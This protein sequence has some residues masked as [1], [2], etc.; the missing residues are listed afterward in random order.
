MLKEK[1]GDPSYD[2]MRTE[3][4]AAASKSALAAA[5][6]GKSLPSWETTWEFVR[7]LEVRVLGEDAED[8]RRRWQARWEECRALLDGDDRPPPG[9]DRPERAVAG[10]AERAE[11]PSTDLSTDGQARRHANGQTRGHMDRPVAM[12]QTEAE[13]G[14]RARARPPRRILF[15]GLAIALGYVLGLGSPAA[16]WLLRQMV[17]DA[18]GRPIPGDAARLDADVTYPDGS[19]VKVGERFVKTWRIENTGQ[20]PWRDRYLDRQPPLDGLDVCHSAR[21]VPV[22][23]TEPGEFALVSVEVEAPSRPGACKVFWKMVDAQA[24]LYFPQLNGVFFEV[25]VVP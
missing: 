17:S 8:A 4:G 20:V 14:A 22:P 25:K 12:G 21:R 11:V 15:Y 23:D 16:F 2:R 1:A 10:R 24:N 6:R 18:P 3:Y 9:D 13:R 19:P 7:A 5:A